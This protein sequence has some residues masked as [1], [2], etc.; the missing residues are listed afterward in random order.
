M[1]R[2]ALLSA[3]RLVAAAGL[4]VIGGLGA[5]ACTASG[6]DEAG[7]TTSTSAASTS[8]SRA[9]ST[10]APSTTT[11]A[12]PET[13][14]SE[15]PPSD[16]LAEGA[17]GPRVEQLQQRLTELRY[18][19]GAVDGKFGTATT[20][21]VWAFQK[22]HG[23]AADGVVTLGVWALMQQGGDPAP[24]V[25]GGG[26]NRVEVDI[27]RQVLLLYQGGQLRL[28]THISSGSRRSYCENGHCGDAV[29]D[30]GS[31][32]FGRRYSGWEDGP[33]GKL[34]NPV[35]FNGGIAVHGASSVPS[36]PASHGCV[37][38][39][40]HIAEYFPS[41]VERGEPVYVIDG[42]A[43]PAIA[44]APPETTTTAPPAETTTTL[45]AETTTTL[46]A[47]T[48]TTLPAETTTV[49]PSSDTTAPPA[50]D[51]PASDTT[52]PS[53]PASLPPISF[54]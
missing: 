51:P 2:P 41:L 21:A 24:L 18:D 10:T 15:A 5:A 25:P 53:M 37:R 45:P 8:T 13:T 36:Y 11:T 52:Q 9:T 35:Y 32:R 22:L 19:P 26:A 48:T 31:F 39:P 14:T 28:I 17:Q 34:Y 1:S 38:I 44:E 54:P 47:E 40:M 23:L 49:P 7:S 3:R 29:T 46:P 30:P 6:A 12:P 50:T 20:Q 4:V 33:L 27:S 42:G 16:V 43:P